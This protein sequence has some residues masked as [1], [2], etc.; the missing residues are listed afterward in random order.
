[1]DI[2][3]TTTDVLS[4]FSTAES[5]RDDLVSESKIALAQVK[6]LQPIL[7]RDLVDRLLE[8]EH[9]E[10]VSKY[11][12]APLSLFVKSI[13]VAQSRGEVGP[14]GVQ[15]YESDYSTAASTEVV[16][17]LGRT[18]RS[19]AGSLLKEAVRAL[20]LDDYADLKQIYDND[21]SRT[22]TSIIGGIIL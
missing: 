12:K 15:Q 17:A 13:V 18:L 10:F 16:D 8:G 3:I 22:Y 20:E 7:G 21:L 19:H 9:E 11:I 6:F 2:L 4:E 5:L 14:M 1:M